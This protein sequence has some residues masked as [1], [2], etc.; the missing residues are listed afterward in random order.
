MLGKAKQLQA[1]YAG[2]IAE[3]TR[4]LDLNKLLA[5]VRP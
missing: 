1:N 4:T 5:A 3:Q 2:Q